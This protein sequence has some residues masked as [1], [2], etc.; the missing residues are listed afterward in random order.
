MPLV[1]FCSVKF[2]FKIF[3]IFNFQTPPQQ[4]E[5]TRPCGSQWS[6]A[7]PF[8][9]LRSSSADS[10]CLTSASLLDAVLRQVRARLTGGRLARYTL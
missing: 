8:V 7:P 9:A 4:R 2:Y 5:A 3:K 10:E 6:P 1:S